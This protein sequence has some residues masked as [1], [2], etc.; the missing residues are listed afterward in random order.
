MVGLLRGWHVL[1]DLLPESGQT[2]LMSAMASFGRNSSVLD[3]LQIA[4]LDLFDTSTW[5]S[6]TTP[7]TYDI[8]AGSS[9]R[10]I[11]SAKQNFEFAFRNLV[12][13]N[14]APK[15]VGLYT[16][17]FPAADAEH[18]GQALPESS[19]ICLWICLLFACF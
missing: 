11:L 9:V 1:T 12:A 15:G 10:Q 6:H 18:I 16:F 8:I 14:L 13:A 2:R 7:H 5:P 4:E 17:W 19:T 3:R